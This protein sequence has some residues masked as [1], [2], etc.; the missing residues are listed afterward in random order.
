ME[1]RTSSF[2]EGWCR[3]PWL[4]WCCTPC[5]WWWW[6]WPRCCSPHSKFIFNPC[7]AHWEITWGTPPVFKTPKCWRAMLLGRWHQNT[8]L[9]R[10]IRRRQHP[11]AWAKLQLSTNHRA[12]YQQLP[13]FQPIRAREAAAPVWRLRKRFARPCISSPAVGWLPSISSRVHEGSCFCPL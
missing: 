9:A 7:S 4:W 2:V 3:P 6:W 12:R 13:P 5:C 1:C 8:A 11:V 10:S